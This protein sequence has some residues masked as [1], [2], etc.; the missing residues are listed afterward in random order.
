MKRR[1]KPQNRKRLTRDEALAMAYLA[2][3]GLIP[4]DLRTKSAR[5]ICAAVEIDHMSALALGGA[6]DFR[7]MQP[8][9][10]PVHR[11]KTK[12]DLRKVHKGRRLRTA[13][14]HHNATMQTRKL[15]IVVDLPSEGAAQAVLG[16]KFH[17]VVALPRGADATHTAPRQAVAT[18]STHDPD[19]PEPTT[20]AVSERR[21]KRMAGRKL[22]GRPF[23]GW[24]SMSGA[25][26]W[27]KDRLAR[28][29][30]KRS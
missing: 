13:Q 22:K 12:N 8:L 16:G 5:E 29:E 17:E 23:Q 9:L 4:E 27:R 21:G 2:I 15:G 1:R 3:P 28:L 11:L 25:V 18:T 20:E 19:A 24:R 7:N 10:K 14:A 26:R 6:D 30:K